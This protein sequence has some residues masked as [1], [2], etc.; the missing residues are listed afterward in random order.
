M[1]H[2]KTIPAA[3]LFLADELNTTQF[4]TPDKSYSPF[5]SNIGLTFGDVGQIDGIQLHYNRVTQKI[6]NPAV[7]VAARPGVE[8]V[9]GQLQSG[10]LLAWFFDADCFAIEARSDIHLNFLEDPKLRVISDRAEDVRL[11]HCM[12][13]TLDPRDPD[14]EFPVLFAIRA[15]KGRWSGNSVVG[16]DTRVAISVQ[17]LDLNVE[18]ARDLLARCPHSADAVRATYERWVRSACGTMELAPKTRGEAE[19]LA[20]ALRTLLFNSAAAPGV[21]SGRIASFSS[22]GG[23]P[24]HFLWDSCFHMLALE[25]M[26]DKLCRDALL[27]LAETTRSDGKVP[28]FVCSTWVRPLAS[29]PALLGWATE[30]YVERTGDLE[31]AKELLPKLRANCDWWLTQRLNSF[32]LVTC[33]DPFETGWDDTPRLDDGDIIAVDMNAFVLWQM[34]SIARLLEATGQPT[35]AAQWRRRADDF[36]A[37]LVSVCW[38]PGRKQFQDVFLENGQKTRRNSPALFLPFLDEVPLPDADVKASISEHLLNPLT[39]DGH[40]P[41]PCISYDDPAY[42]AST[43]WRGPMWPQIS[44]LL[45][46]VLAR[47][48][49]LEASQGKSRRV[50]EIIL[51]EGNLHEY[52]NSQDGSGLGY[53]QQGWTAAIFLRLHID[54]VVGG[55]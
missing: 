50:Y 35:E 30:R 34:R 6:G 37:V 38:D 24:T 25:E 47:H 7:S 3:D 48:G 55:S 20:L 33:F 41:F 42:T 11:V 54:A 12:I 19:V 31:L 46:Q 45:V 27:I 15:L 53:A 29:Q 43:M 36:A 49:F 2:A 4:D 32:G 44:W 22:R 26:D 23:Y 51:E 17:L 10:P 40:I 13:K 52:F 39:F 28:H 18:D 8:P 1:Q 16:R 5:Y 21:F 9:C 14:E